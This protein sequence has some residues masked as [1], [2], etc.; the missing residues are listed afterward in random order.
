MAMNECFIILKNSSD[1]DLLNMDDK[2]LNKL[3]PMRPRIQYPCKIKFITHQ[4][5]NLIKPLRGI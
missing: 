4:E 2:L 3:R 1:L 5:R